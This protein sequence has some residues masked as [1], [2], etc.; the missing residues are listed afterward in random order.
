[1]RQ[2]WT[3]LEEMWAHDPPAVFARFGWAAGW[4]PDLPIA[5]VWLGVSA[6]RQRE[7]DERVPDL[8]ATPAAV[9]FVSAEPLLGAIDLA[10][11]LGAGGEHPNGARFWNATG[12]GW[13]IA[14]GESG[15]GARPMHPDWARSLRDQC[16]AAGV[17]FFFKQHGEWIGVPDLRNLPGG[18]GPGFGAFDWCEYDAEAD[19]VRTGKARAGRLLDGREWNEMPAPA[20]PAAGAAA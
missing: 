13:V 17:P 20:S 3:A 8:L 5:N 18:H 15:K 7:A 6:E 1:M 14:G 9:R 11:W 16:Q 2:Y 19:A 4:L 10:A 12:I